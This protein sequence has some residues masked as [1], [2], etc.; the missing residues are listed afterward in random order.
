MIHFAI[1]KYIITLLLLLGEI[2]MRNYLLKHRI[3][4]KRKISNFE[5]HKHRINYTL[6]IS[7]YLFRE[8][9][10]MLNIIRLCYIYKNI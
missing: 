10:Y 1:M 2:T 3:L 8:L 5:Y 9:I 6:F 4:K 7:K